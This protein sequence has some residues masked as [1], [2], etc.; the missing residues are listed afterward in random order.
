MGGVHVVLLSSRDLC[1]WRAVLARMNI[2]HEYALDG[3]FFVLKE[4][5]ASLFAGMF[6]GLLCITYLFP[7][8]FGLNRFDLLFLAAVAIQIIFVYFRLETI[9]EA[10]TISLFHVIGL[11]LELYKTHPSV[12]SWSYAEPGIFHISTVPLYTGFM[13]AAIG[14]YVAQAWKYLHLRIEHHPPYWVSMILC[15]LIYLNFFTNHFI[16]DFRLFL[17]LAVFILYRKT[18]VYFT[19]RVRE[20]HLPLILG[21]LLIGFFVWIAENVGTFVGA[22]TYPNQVHVWNVV[23]YQKITSWFLLVII[24]F[25]LV[26]YLKHVKATRTI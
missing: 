16:Y 21:F 8:P 1:G 9:D 13:Y 22:W 14:S 26:A 6:L 12:G 23:S 18:Q 7:E 19:P 2:F 15:G 3:V 25:I 17:F 4:A 10:K 24:C 20:Y 11:V 5:R